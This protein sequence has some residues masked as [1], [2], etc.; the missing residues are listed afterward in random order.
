M[1]TSTE[2]IARYCC[3][4]SSDYGVMRLFHQTFLFSLCCNLVVVFQWDFSCFFSASFK[5]KTHNELSNIRYG[6]Q[7][8][9]KFCRFVKNTNLLRCVWA[10]N[11]IFVCAQSLSRYRDKKLKQNYSNRNKYLIYLKLKIMC[12]RENEWRRDCGDSSEWVRERE[13]ERLRNIKLK[14]KRQSTFICKSSKKSK[15]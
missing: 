13:W 10:H 3:C 12:K 1:Y 14:V 2:Y 15:D 6:I 4:L 8:P 9:V 5:K 11:I 7:F